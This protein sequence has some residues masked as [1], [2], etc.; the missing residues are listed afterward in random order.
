[1]IIATRNRGELKKVRKY[2][3]IFEMI[4]LGSVTSPFGEKKINQINVAVQR[5]MPAANKFLP[6][7]FESKYYS[8]IRNS[9]RWF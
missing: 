8:S 3:G 9:S 1:M 6:R 4:V 2:K 7:S 5:I